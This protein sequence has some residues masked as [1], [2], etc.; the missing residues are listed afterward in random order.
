MCIRD[1]SYTITIV[2][3]APQALSEKVHQA[4]STYDH[5]HV[6]HE[7]KAGLS[8][9]RNT[10]ITF[11][12]GDWL[13]FIDDDALVPDDYIR[14]IGDIIHEETWDCFGGHINSWWKYE[15]PD[16]L[17]EEFGSKPKLSRHRIV[18]SDKYNWGS[19]I[20]IRRDCL[21]R[22]GK[23][24]DKIGMKGKQLGYAAEN[25]VQDKLRDQGYTIGYD[26]QLYV[27]HLVL[28]QKLKLGWHIKSAY[29]T[30][31]D[32]RSVFPDQYDWKGMLVSAKNCISRPLK[33]VGFWLA[34]PKTCLLYTSPSPRD[35]ST[36]R[37]PSSA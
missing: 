36:S 14:R 26:P 2:N 6:I 20:I 25:I 29:A 31:R 23:F 3:N 9:A 17:H 27:D 13:A 8:I 16:W 28:P 33:A 10:G 37:M 15:R 35:L 32:G 4:L 5:V 22:V 18:L 21:I 7:K 30:G 19:N 1:R 11:V 34:N 12:N 24:P